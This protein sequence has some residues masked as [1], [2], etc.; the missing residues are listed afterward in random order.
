MI[1][2]TEVDYVTL[3]GVTIAIMELIKMTDTEEKYKRFYPLASAVIGAGLAL[4]T[5]MWWF[6]ALTVG[7]AASG[8]YKA[9]KMSIMGKGV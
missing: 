2:N 1:V 6:M 7:L 4:A 8:V 3:V 9:A 5:G